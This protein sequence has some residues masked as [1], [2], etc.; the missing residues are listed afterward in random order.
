MAESDQERLGASL[1]VHAW[2]SSTSAGARGTE[3]DTYWIVSAFSGGAKMLVPHFQKDAD[4]V[5][6]REIYLNMGF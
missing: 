3:L 5:R 4:D 6:P 2:G 1:A